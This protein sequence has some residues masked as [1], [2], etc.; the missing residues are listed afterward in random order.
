[1]TLPEGTEIDKSSK[2]PL[3]I[4]VSALVVAGGFF[5]YQLASLLHVF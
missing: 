4:L 5:V 1:M 2:T 3:I